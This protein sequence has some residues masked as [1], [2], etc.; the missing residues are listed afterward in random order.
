[1]FSTDCN[2]L[3][4]TMDITLDGTFNKIIPLQLFGLERAP[5]LGKIFKLPHYHSSM[6][7]SP[8]KHFT[9]ISNRVCLFSSLRSFMVFGEMPLRSTAL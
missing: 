8:S 7:T 2:L 9:Q 5:F 4:I 1:M 3:I 6:L